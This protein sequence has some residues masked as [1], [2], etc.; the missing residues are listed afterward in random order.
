MR[1]GVNAKVAVQLVQQHAGSEAWLDGHVDPLQGPR[2]VYFSLNFVTDKDVV[3][4]SPDAAVTR[5]ERLTSCF[6][7][8]KPAG[9]VKLVQDAGA[10][11]AQSRTLRSP[12][13]DT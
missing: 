1:S 4:A 6:L 11:R 9:K 10:L 3:N 5:G 13:C 8:H 7:L 12:F 2:G